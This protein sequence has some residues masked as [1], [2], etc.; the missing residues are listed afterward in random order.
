MAW[1]LLTAALAALAMGVKLLLALKTR[2][3]NDVFYWQEF[4]DTMHRVGGI[5]VYYEIDYFNH[6]PFMLH[7]LQAMDRLAQ[8]TG[9]PFA[10]WLRVPAIV[11]DSASL[12]VLCALFAS[13]PMAPLLR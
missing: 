6:P 4:L 13:P 3:T 9:L 12:L 7:V 5:G 1:T 10:F 2:G 8:A 11:A